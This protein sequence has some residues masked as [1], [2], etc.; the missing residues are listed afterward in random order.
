MT[1]MRSRIETMPAT[2]SSSRTGRWRKPPWIMSAA[3]CAVS[4]EAS[5]VSG[6]VVS[7]SRTRALG[8]PD[9]DGLEDVPLGEDAFEPLAVHHEH[10]ADAARDHAPG[11]FGERLVGRGTEQLPRHV[12]GDHGH[13]PRS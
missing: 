4:S 2:A 7:Q 3:A 13:R 1:R 9:R 12:F 11:R 6:F 8:R 10:G 5:I